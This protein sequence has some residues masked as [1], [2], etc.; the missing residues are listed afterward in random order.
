MF[1][2]YSLGHESS[3]IQL[4]SASQTVETSYI[5]EV[6][7]RDV[8][9]KTKLPVMTL[10]IKHHSMFIRIC[11][12]LYNDGWTHSERKKS[13]NPFV[14]SWSSGDFLITGILLCLSLCGAKV[15]TSEHI[16]LPVDKITTSAFGWHDY[17][18]PNSEGHR[19]QNMIHSINLQNNPTLNRNFQFNIML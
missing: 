17:H 10:Q 16:N 15:K 19:N 9:L 2:S 3:E 7:G 11:V 14:G 4:S 8:S 6:Q 1:S 5:F 12:Y 18:L 13:K